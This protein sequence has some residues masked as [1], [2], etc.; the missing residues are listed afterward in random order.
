[1]IATLG[2]M[3]Q[4]VAW[5]FSRVLGINDNEPV[6]HADLEHAHWDAVSREWLIHEDAHASSFDR[7]A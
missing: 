1:M 7:A 3:T 6:A 2:V 4:A 5:G